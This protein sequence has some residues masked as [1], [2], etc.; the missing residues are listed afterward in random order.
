MHDIPEDN[1]AEKATLGSIL[2][3]RDAITMLASWFQGAFFYQA[4]H[5]WIYEA[6]LA[7]YQKSITP[8]VRVVADLLRDANRLDAI[9][10][11]DYLLHLDDE[12]PHGLDA[13]VF[14]RRVESCALRR[15]LLD[16]SAEIAALAQQE[17]D[18]PQAVVDAQGKLAEVAAMRRGSGVG[19]FVP[20][21]QIV[22][23][24]YDDLDTQAEPGAATGFR[25]LDKIT[26]G[27]HGGDLIILGARPA[28]GKSSWAMCL[29]CNVA[30]LHKRPVAVASLEMG[31]KQLLRRAAAAYI[32]V[33][34]AAVRDNILDD[35]QRAAFMQ[36][37]GWAAQQ[38]VFVNDKAGQTTQQIRSHML[39]LQAEYGQ[40]GLVVVDYL[41]L[42]RGTG[43]KERWQEVGE[44]SVDLKNLARE[45]DTPV[46]ALSQLSRA[47]EGRTSKVPMLSDLRESG[48]LEQDADMVMFLYREELYNA[49]TDKKGIAELHIAKHRNGQVGVVPMRFEPSTTKFS[50]LS[51][52][53]PDGY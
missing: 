1:E 39:R 51:Y 20:F 5:A 36:A 22:D 25:D 30:D 49:E 45:L 44:F 27:L 37:L 47:V 17:L 34:L 32:G 13:E 28:V 53:S 14:A 50:D 33:D 24:V 11:L 6:M 35:Q 31:R 12:I 43:K 9:G 16:V 42:M 21:C 23:E 2:L 48:N 3:H 8:N 4:K 19:G 38:P 52:R 29:A 15:K 46:L 10:G 7:C 40:L 41:Q 26:G 18:G